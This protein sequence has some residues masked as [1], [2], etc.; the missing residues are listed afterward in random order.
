MR[1]LDAE[2]EA[3]YLRAI[4]DDPVLKHGIDELRNSFNTIQARAQMLLSL[5]A[6]C[7]TI[8]GFSGPRMAASGIFARYGL[9]VGLL[10]ALVSACIL[11]T[12]PLNLQWVTAER[13]EASDDCLIE[14]IKRRNK[15][16][17]R[18]RLATL[19]LVLGLSAYV[20]AVVAFLLTPAAANATP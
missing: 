4:Y 10:L 11:L 16:T 8:T 6:L 19:I 12:G 2:D 17:N 3:T 7:L 14:L 18:L 13:A 9:A 1:H 5:I 20:L 15:R